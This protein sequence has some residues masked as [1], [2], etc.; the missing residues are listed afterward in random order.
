MRIAPTLAVC[1]C[2]A[3]ASA[4]HTPPPITQVTETVNWEPDTKHANALLSEE[5]AGNGIEV[6]APKIY[7]DASLRLMLDATRATLATMSGLNQGALTASLGSLNGATIS[8]TQFGLQISG[9]ASLPTT[10]TT[11]TG[12]TG[13]TTTNLNLPSTNSTLPG[14]STVAT[15]PT[16]STTINNTPTPATIPVVP[17]GLAFTP[18]GSVSPSSLDL[19]N[20]E[21]QLSSA[22]TGYE[23]L[24]EGSLSDRFVKNLRAVKPRVTMGFPISLRT[25]AAYRDA[26]AVVEV[27]V[28]LPAD[29]VLTEQADLKK[30]AL[31]SLYS[32]P[33][34]RA[35]VEENENRAL[36]HDRALSDEP[37]AVTTLLPQEK[38]Y[39]VAAMTDHMTSIGAG[40]VVGTVGV[41][42][43]GAWGHKSLYLVQDQ[44][45]VAMLRPPKKDEK[46]A[47]FLW[48]FRPVLGQRYV[49]G[50][51]KQTF[52]QLAFPELSSVDCYGAVLIHTYW[53]QFDRDTGLVG[54]VIAQSVLTSRK[55]FSIPH[56]KLAPEVARIDYQDLGDGTLAV[57]LDGPQYLTGTYIQFGAQRYEV[58]KNLIVDETGARFV[59]PA[60]TVAQWTGQVVARSG[61]STPILD[62]VAQPQPH[63][64]NQDVCADPSAKGIELPAVPAPASQCPVAHV[65]NAEVSPLNESDSRLRLEVS[66]SATDFPR[67][68]VLLAIGSKVFGLRDAP[69]WRDHTANSD[70]LTANAPTALLL[71]NP[72]VRVF[73]PFLTDVGDPLARC[74]SASFSL[75]DFAN[76]DSSA[77]RLV[78][79]SLDKKGD[80]TYLLYG[81]HLTHFTNI[82]VPDTGVTLGPLDNVSGEYIRRVLVTKA[83]LATTKKIVL[84]RADGERPLVLELPAATVKPTSIKVSADS[85]VVQGTQG[86]DVSAEHARGILSVKY[87]DRAVHFAWVR[88]SDSSVL[89]ATPEPTSS[90]T[91]IHFTRLK[92]DGVTDQQRSADLA[93]K[94]RN[95]DSATLKLDVVA[96]RVFVKS[97][98]KAAATD[99]TS[100]TP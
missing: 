73:Q 3:V 79:I 42:A 65:V 9:P 97:A 77:E 56:Y 94:Y 83:A 69:L 64:L 44:D 89:L 19:L 15:N 32:L 76:P 53:R 78:F 96:A 13:T 7:D 75:Q 63:P 80:A 29:K 16:E 38:T 47:G 30:Q 11:L 88:E 72:R 82:L 6:G 74:L 55:R 35:R 66:Y 49:R 46:S 20:E 5:T 87:K 39:N 51:M 98:D 21:M 90:D 48:Q 67:D 58:G 70:K 81:N 37:P 10:A 8:Q 24:L 23:L 99:S 45:T 52:V 4:C 95:G 43:T 17:S 1:L 50:G 25:P 36:A 14:S 84:Q 71:A 60:S 59:V 91:M 12:P 26:V 27:E 68:K 31:V 57:R 33:E 100:S 18:P 86:L 22:I 92:D 85:P 34:D 61:E 28:Q 2:L 62:L 41:G 93:I 40:V 54:P